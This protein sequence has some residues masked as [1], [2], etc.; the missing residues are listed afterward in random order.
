M[1]CNPL[2]TQGSSG[3]DSG[4]QGYPPPPISVRLGGGRAG[5][6]SLIPAHKA[7]QRQQG[8]PEHDTSMQGWVGCVIT[9][10]VK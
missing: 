5:P 4:A 6:W 7:G 9:K 1:A 10:S 3:P 2:G 8:A